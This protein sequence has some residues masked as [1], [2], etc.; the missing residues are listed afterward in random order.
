MAKKVIKKVTKTAKAKQR[1]PLQQGDVLF[2]PLDKL[3]NG[4]KEV[5]VANEYVIASSAV[6]G[7]KHVLLMRGNKCYNATKISATFVDIKTPSIVT[8]STHN[9]HTLT[10]GIWEIRFVQ[11]RSLEGHLQR[12][13]D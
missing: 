2:I 1:I 6:T 3:P 13:L 8:H 7:H 10:N 9:P 4:A 11:E 12:V 5:S